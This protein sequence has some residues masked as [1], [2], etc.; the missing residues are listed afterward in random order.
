[1]DGWSG[2][3]RGEFGAALY[4]FS[5]DGRRNYKISDD[6][7]VD[8]MSTTQ[9]I[10]AIQGLAHLGTSEG[11]VIRVA[12]DAKTGRWSS[13][14]VKSLPEAPQ[15]FVR[16]NDGRMF[17]TL[18]DS[19]ALITSDN[20]LEVLAKR[21]DWVRPDT[22]VTSADASRIYVGTLQ[23]VCEYDMSNK[24][25]RY[26]VPNLSFINKLPKEQ[27]ENIRKRYRH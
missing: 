5:N 24:R 22:I 2:S 23:Y 25:L 12:P 7:V 14:E 18:S 17:L 26:L 16:L 10:I 15:A 6:Q 11:S 8:F 20:E 21:T 1:M 27:E 4:W 3:T 19:L 9:G 13:T